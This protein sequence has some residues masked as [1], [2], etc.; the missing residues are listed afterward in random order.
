MLRAWATPGPAAWPYSS[1]RRRDVVDERRLVLADDDRA[2]AR[3]N[4]EVGVRDARRKPHI[5]H[6]LERRGVGEHEI[7][8]ELVA[9]RSGSD[10]EDSETASP[11]DVLDAPAPVLG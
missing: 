6:D 2:T 7:P 9:R 1:E 5:R 11:V 4:R 3:R 10:H 8:P